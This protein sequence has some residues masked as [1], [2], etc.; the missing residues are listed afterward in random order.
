ME[1][2]LQLSKEIE[3]HDFKHLAACDKINLIFYQT[4]YMWHKWRSSGVTGF[5]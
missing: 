1:I 3:A 5:V 4:A 2:W